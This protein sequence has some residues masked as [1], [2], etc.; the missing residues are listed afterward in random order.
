MNEL[1]SLLEEL[2]Q[3][4]QALVLGIVV[5]AG[6]LLGRK[7][8]KTRR[9]G[10][11]RGAS[12][13]RPTLRTEHASPRDL[14]PAEVGAL[15]FTYAPSKDGAP[16]PGEVV[17]AWVPYAEHDGRGKDRPVLIIAR[18]DSR[19]VAGCYL[20]TKGHR[21]FLELGAGPWDGQGRPSYLN[22]ERVLRVPHDAMRREGA[23]LDRQRYRAMTEAI[24]RRHAS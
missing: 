1:Q 14:S 16:D 20:S 11:G 19:T 12:G 18:I 13:A 24:A 15:N 22:P 5:V 17:W 8:T 6:V 21:G 9:G 4:A 2:P 23:V 10:K 7:G 3:W